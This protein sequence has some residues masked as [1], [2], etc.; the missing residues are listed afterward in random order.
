MALKFGSP[1][2]ARIIGNAGATHVLEL[3]IIASALTIPKAISSAGLNAS[4]VDHF[5]INE[6]F[7]L[8]LLQTKRCLDS[9]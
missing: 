2:I 5:E 3:F 9:I 8:W 7:L 4:Q 1:A 6:V